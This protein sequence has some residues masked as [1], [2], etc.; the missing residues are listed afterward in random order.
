LVIFGGEKGGEEEEEGK[1]Q[2]EEGEVEGEEG[3]DEGEEESER[4]GEEGGWEKETIVED[5][6]QVNSFVC[7][8]LLTSCT[9]M[10]DPLLVYVH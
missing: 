6:H 3:E 7:L 2:G 9:S 10:L 5:N 4:R 8:L 1:E